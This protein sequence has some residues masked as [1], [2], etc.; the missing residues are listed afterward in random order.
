M[1]KL[2]F[3]ASPK[4]D[5]AVVI[6]DTMVWADNKEKFATNY[7]LPIGKHL[8][9]PVGQRVVVIG[10]YQPKTGKIKKAELVPAADQIL[11][12]CEING[13]TNLIVADG[14]YFKYLTGM[15]AFEKHIG[16]KFEC[17]IAGCEELV[18]TPSVNFATI[19][20]FP[21]K[22]PL[23]DLANKTAAAIMAGNFDADEAFEFESYALIEDPGHLQLLFDEYMGYEYIACDIE[24]TGLYVGTTELLTIAFAKDEHNAFTVPLH[25]EYGDCS[26]L[27]DMVRGFLLEYGGSLVFHNGLFD[28]KH[29]IYN[30]FMQN[31]SDIDGMLQ[32][33][34]AMKFDDTFILAY[35]AL[36]STVRPSLGLKDL[37]YEFLGDYAEDVKEAIKVPLVDLAEYNAKDVCGTYY[38]FNKFKEKLSMPVYNTIMKPS[39]KPLLKMMLN[40]M[41]LDLSKVS[42]VKEML[43]A[44]LKAAEETLRDD[45]YVKL[46]VRQ[47]RQTAAEKYNERTKVKKKTPGDFMDMVFNPNSSAQ[48]RILLFDVMGFEPVDF[49]A[50]KAPKTDRASIKE[51]LELADIEQKPILEALVT[52]SQAGIVLNTFINAFE[53]LS[54]TQDGH[55]TLHGSLVLGGTQ[56]GRLSSRDPNMQNLPSNS[57]WGKA[58]KSCF[59]APEGWLFFGADF[60]ALE[61]RIGAILSKDPAKLKENLLGFDGHSLRAL[62]FFPDELEEAG[63][64]DI[65]HDD[66]DSVNRIKNEASDLRQNAKPVS[67]LKQYGGGAGKI[68][69]VLKCSKQRADEISNAYDNLYR[70]TLQFNER[71]NEFARQNGYVECAFGL[72][73]KTPRIKAR[74]KAVASSEE[75]SSNNAVTQ[76]WGMLMNRAF[77]EFDDRIEADGMDHDVIPT[78]TIHDAMYGLVKATPEAVA[79]VNKNLIECMEWQDHPALES[80]ISLGAELDIGKA[81]DKQ[82]T[83]PND[84]TIGG[85]EEIL[86]EITNETM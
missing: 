83:L 63:L 15:K 43:E 81:W 51:F 12:Y 62:A 4:L 68:Q 74:D 75:R 30:M 66:P 85:I 52:I 5:T 71:N 9:E 54:I 47:L 56:S 26:E 50:K 17:V 44:D 11:N 67:F 14:D 3:T 29:I 13:I 58:I 36:N 73:L 80:E 38:V 70:V 42:V 40:G 16:E 28:A 65:D 37:A 79:W 84:I 35:L 34:E 61:D 7:F 72:E 21:E 2:T 46:V 45:S 78:N 41:P 60:N 6:K 76:S 22:Q 59:V 49:T 69:K 27:F 1:T 53:E 39:F 20:M 24:T 31:F 77:I 55:T 86:K 19:D 8:G 25:S 10:A 48:L 57:K 64:G 82:H 32:G 23:L 18:I 33:L